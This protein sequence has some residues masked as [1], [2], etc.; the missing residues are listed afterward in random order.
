MKFKFINEETSGGAVVGT[1]ITRIERFV[2]AIW[3]PLK[4]T[5]AAV[6]A[7][8][9]ANIVFPSQ[10]LS[11]SAVTHTIGTAFQASATK[12]VNGSYAVAINVQSLLL[13]SAEQRVDLFIG[14]TSGSQTLLVDTAT[15]KTAGV[16]NLNN[17]QTLTLKTKIPIG[18]Y[19]KLVSTN[20]SGTGSATWVSGYEQTEG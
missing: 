7:Y 10:V 11:G 4:V 14:A 19:A 12:V 1:D 18:W 8:V 20:V 5:W 16:L 2:G 13:G 6:L 15:L 17:T 9:Q 3:T